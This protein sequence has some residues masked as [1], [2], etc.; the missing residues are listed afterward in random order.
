MAFNQQAL[1]NANRNIELGRLPLWSGPKDSTFSAEQWVERIDK[2]RAA[3]A[4]NW[5]NDTTMSYVFNALR[6]DAL[7][8]YDALPTLGYDNTVWDDFKEAFIRTYG[9]TKTARTAAL[10]LAEIK[11]GVKRVISQIHSQS[12]Q[13]H[14]R[15]QRSG[16]SSTSGTGSTIRCSLYG[17]G[18][19]GR[20]GPS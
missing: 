9:T 11:Q 18:R 20:C 4:G 10:N 6:G 17:I 19:L 16:T 14:D 3:T 5:N 8:W 15:R 12:H 2:A 1:I 13:A 7:V